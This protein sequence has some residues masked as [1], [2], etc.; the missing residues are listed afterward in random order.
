MVHGLAIGDT[1]ELDVEL[2]AA[3]GTALATALASLELALNQVKGALGAVDKDE[4]AGAEGE[5]LAS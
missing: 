5:D 1:G 4:P 2:A 3:L